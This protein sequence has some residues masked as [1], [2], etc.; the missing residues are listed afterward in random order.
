MLALNAG[1]VVGGCARAALVPMYCLFF[2]H[3]AVSAWA[4][5]PECVRAS[6]S[7]K[8]LEPT[9]CH[10]VPELDWSFRRGLT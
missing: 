1:I 5:L 9:T 10:N 8:V 2:L 6:K 7:L 4:R 3:G